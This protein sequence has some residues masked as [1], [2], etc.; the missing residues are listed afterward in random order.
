MQYLRA[1]GLFLAFCLL[2]SKCSVF[3][4]EHDQ[5]IT[6]DLDQWVPYNV[7]D[8]LHFRTVGLLDEYLDVKMFEHAW[9]NADTDC[10]D[11]IEYIQVHIT[12][13][14]SFEDSLSV[15]VSNN[16]VQISYGADLNMTY[17][18]GQT[19]YST[20]T[21]SLEFHDSMSIGGST[22]S[23]VLVVTCDE[24]NNLSELKFSKTFG[25][26]EYTYNGLLYSIVP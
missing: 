11:D 24:C 13:R 25:L 9:R 4:C 21:T 3:D 12:S 18:E 1:A 20:S 10:T 7:N 22:Y 14:N 6:E 16:N 2:F 26:V 8:E 15:Y 19:G 23:N 17:I 5:P